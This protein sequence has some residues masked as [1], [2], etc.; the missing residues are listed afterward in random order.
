MATTAK[1]Q[2]WVLFLVGALIL[3]PVLVLLMKW[4]GSAALPAGDYGFKI[5]NTYPHDPTAFTQGLIWHDGHLYETTGRFTESRL[6][7][8]ELTTGKV[9]QEH[10][11][12]DD[13]FGEGMTMLGDRIYQ[14]TW[15]SGIAIVYDAKTFREQKRFRYG[16]EGWGLTHDNKHLIMSNGTSRLVFRDPETFDEVRSV[17]VKYKDPRSGKDVVVQKLN[18]LEYV[19]GEVL[20]NIWKEDMIARIDPKSGRV[21]G[22][23]N[24]T[25]LKSLGG[26]IAGEVLNGIAY[27]EKQDRLF[28]TGKWWPKLFEI[29]L[30]AKKK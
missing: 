7:K 16:G 21:R 1:Q 11:L 15:Q 10:A 30:V 25:T 19:N 26:V 23:I 3:A 4:P 29:E 6:R 14:I 17:I 2:R 20:A 8:V 5:V 28:V 9:V 24:L 18:E 13:L 12:S 22:W 27:D